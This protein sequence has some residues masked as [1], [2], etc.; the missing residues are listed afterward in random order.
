MVILLVALSLSMD[1]FS[2]AIVYGMFNFS[3]KE[4]ITLSIIVGIYHFFM[5]LLGNYLGNIIF[6]LIPIE[7]NIV[8][9][10]IFI[11]I[12]IEMIVDTLKNEE[13]HSI[14]NIIQMLIFGFAVSI[15]SFS[16]GLGLKY[17]TNNYILSS[18]TFSFFSFLLTYIGLNFGKKIGIK[19]GNLSTIIGSIILIMLGLIYLFK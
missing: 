10:I 13:H 5:P 11:L 4:E 1:A 17:L 16:V 9:G 7:M 18:L 19:I 2:L 8:V 15:D 6:N 12:G 3:K 14:S